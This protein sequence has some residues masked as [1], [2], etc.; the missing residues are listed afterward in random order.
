ML[1]VRWERL[2]RFH[3]TRRIEHM[4][5]ALIAMAEKKKVYVE[6]SVISNL[7]ARPS[8]NV[9]DAAMQMQTL[10]WWAFAPER[11][12]L[13]ASRLV[14]EEASRGDVEAAKRRVEL[15]NELQM[16]TID[17][18]AVNLAEKLLEATAVP[19]NSFDDALHIAIAA[20]NK[21]DFLVTWNCKHIANSETIPIIAHVCESAGYRC[22]IIC[23]PP[24]LQGD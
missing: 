7:T 8:H 3:R 18:S 17:D 14:L 12:G 1:N 22:P 21:M 13:F 24:T 16:L 4:R 10:N 9:T 15:V 11:Y 20:I 5:D 2:K 6:T 23:I 19:R